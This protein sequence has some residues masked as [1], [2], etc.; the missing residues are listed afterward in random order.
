MTATTEFFSTVEKDIQ[1]LVYDYIK[2]RSFTGTANER[3]AEHFLLQTLAQMPYFQQNPA[4]F[5]AYALPGDPFARS[6]VWA[7]RKGR[8]NKTVVLM[9]HYDVV[10]IED[11][12]ALGELAFSPDQLEEELMKLRHNFSPEV[13]QDI[14]SGSY[15]FG[16]GSCDMKAGGA[17]QLALLNAYGQEADFS[18]NVILIAV[19]D[20]ENLSAGMRAAVKLLAELKQQYQLDYRLMINSEPHQRKTP[21]RGLFSVGSVGKMMPFF[22]VRGS[23]AHA[24]KVFEGL[25]PLH[26]LSAIVRSTEL[27]MD[28]SDTVGKEAAPAP[29]WLYLRDGKERY[30]VSMPLTAYGC[31]SVLTLWQTPEQMMSKIR[32]ICEACFA[33]VLEEM[34]ASYR[35]FLEQTHQAVKPLP[36][37]VKVVDVATLMKEAEQNYGQS[38]LESYQQELRKIE[39]ALRSNQ[40]TLIEANQLLLDCIYNFI[41]DPAPRIVIGLTPPYYPNVCNRLC[42][43]D[44]ADILSLG[45]R[46]SDYSERTFGLPYDEEDYFTGI[47]DLSYSAASEDVSDQLR[48]Y[49]PLFGR[50]Y[51]IPS[52]EIMQIS[53]PCINIGPWGKDFHKM[54]ERVLKEDLYCC[55]PRI[56]DQ[57]LREML[58]DPA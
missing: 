36:W 51:D 6:V 50:L 54:T 11:Y 35:I 27:N 2:T 22:Y 47:C 55:T 56:L 40:K 48:V 4:L 39:E 43:P 32:A 37:Q 25:N 5:G 41:D 10:T 53:M 31:L 30:D 20:E 45:K 52:E 33:A 57:A 28:L 46:L 34:N 15:L 38:F 17:I 21:D 12:K 44:Q 7:L 58:S 13:Q 8:G 16:R 49:M 1:T 29:T 3:E 9:H 24:G 14:E 42:F 23:L 26:L 19:P 18:G